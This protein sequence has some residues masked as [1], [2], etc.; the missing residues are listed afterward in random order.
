MQL[1]TMYSD[2]D[3]RVSLCMEGINAIQAAL[4]VPHPG[5]AEKR[6]DIMARQLADLSHARQAEVKSA[7]PDAK[8]VMITG[9]TLNAILDRA[10]VGG[11]GARVDATG[12]KNETSSD[13][14]TD[15]GA[16]GDEG[17]CTPKGALLMGHKKRQKLPEHATTALKR[18]LYEHEERPYPSE[19][20]KKQLTY[21]TGLSI[22]QINNW[23]SN[24]R[25]RYIN[26]GKGNPKG[27]DAAV[28]IRAANT[29]PPGSK[30]T[31]PVANRPI[32]PSPPAAPPSSN[33]LN[34]MTLSNVLDSAPP[35][36]LNPADSGAARS[37]QPL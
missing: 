35:R 26:S 8:S 16:D 7:T 11:D 34:A 23:F 30:P 17:F 28:A 24:A 4:G 13:E 31:R 12:L 29:A 27:R 19:E 20:D 32:L 2:L 37:G 9:G 25:R 6:K 22:V 21:S 5:D 14:D 33:P 3:A 18:W 15:D 1:N 10:Q 36:P